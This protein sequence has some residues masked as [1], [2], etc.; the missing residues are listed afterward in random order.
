MA[1]KWMAGA[2]KRPGAFG[3]KA[4]SAGMSTQAYARKMQHAKGRTGKQARLAMT[5]AE[6]AANRAGKRAARKSKG[7][8][9][10]GGKRAAPFKKG[11]GRQVMSTRNFEGKQ[12]QQ[13]GPA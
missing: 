5:F 6:I 1:N 7:K 9:N 11:G 4:K 10:F 13:K 3:A 12:R 8:G 2:V